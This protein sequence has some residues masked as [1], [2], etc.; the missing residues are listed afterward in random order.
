MKKKT[1]KK[2]MLSKACISKLQTQNAVKGG[3]DTNNRLCFVTI[4]FTDCFGNG[5]CSVLTRPCP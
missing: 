5:D 1:I 2:L 3:N 4:Q